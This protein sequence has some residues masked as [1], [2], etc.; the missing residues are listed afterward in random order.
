M[1][2]FMCM[3]VRVIIMIKDY[4]CCVRVQY[5]VIAAD[6]VLIPKATRL[7][8]ERVHYMACMCMSLCFSPSYWKTRKRLNHCQRRK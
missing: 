1:R 7:K 4:C 2:V 5:D 6:V 8:E 3:H